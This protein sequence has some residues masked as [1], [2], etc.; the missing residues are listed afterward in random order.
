MA[1]L[2]YFYNDEPESANPSYL[3]RSLE[4][5]KT[6]TIQWINTTEDPDGL[7]KDY[8][9]TYSPTVVIITPEG[10][11]LARHI[12]EITREQVFALMNHVG[13]VE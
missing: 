11:E 7:A 2:I 5:N 8:N 4:T 10:D 6:A 9:I 1:T 12:G 13:A 3:M